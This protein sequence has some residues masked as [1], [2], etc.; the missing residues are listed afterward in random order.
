MS[1]VGR[2]VVAVAMLAAGF[3]AGS[4]WRAP[5]PSATAPPTPDAVTQLWTCGMHPQVIQDHPGFCPICGMALTPLKAKSSTQAAQITIDPVVVQNMGVRMTTVT[6]AP[7]HSTL[8]AVGYLAEAEP[9]QHDVN[10][11]VSGWIQ[12]LYADTEGVHVDAGAPLFDLYSPELQVAV[13]ELIAARRAN[14]RVGAN[15]SAPA[16]IYDA[17]VRKLTLLGIGAD[18][19]RRLAQREHAPPAITF[20]SPIAGHLVEKAVVDGAAVK[21]G[22]RVM[23]IV[24]HSTL[25]LDAQVYEQQ[26]GVIHIGQAVSATVTAR[27]GVRFIGEISFIHPH[28]DPMTRT[29]MVRVI[30]RNPALTL[31]PNMY[32][33]V[34]IATELSSNA[35]VIPRE[36]IIDSGTRQIAFVALD[37]GHFE[38]RQ[39]IL[40]AQGDGMVEVR[41]GLAPGEHVVTSGQ[42]LLDSESRMQEAIQKHLAQRLL[43]TDGGGKSRTEGSASALPGSAEAPP[44]NRSDHRHGQ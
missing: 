6:T 29:A 32:A 25:W 5:A 28:V 4:Y 15:S 18:Q 30:L 16:A 41:A 40:G 17:A 20:T 21:A 19:I 14:E 13:E 8:R 7:L 43:V 10:L 22:D 26:L 24:D 38:P 31:R 27:P 42:F 9:N 2:L 37:A 36:A 11:R 44:S 33:T 1:R 34:E 35:V 12:H 23:R 3:A 39:L